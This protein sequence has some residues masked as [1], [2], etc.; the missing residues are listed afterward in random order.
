MV[1][2]ERER[3]RDRERGRARE[4]EGEREIEGEGDV[5][6]WKRVL[7]YIWW[8]QCNSAFGLVVAAGCT[9]TTKQGRTQSAT[10]RQID[11]HTNWTQHTSKRED[12]ESVWRQSNSSSSK[13]KLFQQFDWRAAQRLTCPQHN[14]QHA[15]YMPTAH[16]VN[17]PNTCPQHVQTRCSVRWTALW[18]TQGNVGTIRQTDR[19]TDRQTEKSVTINSDN[20]K[21][22]EC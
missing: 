5:S 14:S 20:E 3:E 2:M 8:I 15:Q 9:A 22:T 16:A 10:D 13:C 1:H 19:Q 6:V 18:Y 11:T 12:A 7:S 17:M 21:G 4:R